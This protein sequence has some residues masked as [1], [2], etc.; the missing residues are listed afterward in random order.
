M[1]RP[2]ESILPYMLNCINTNSTS[3]SNSLCAFESSPIE[4]LCRLVLV[5]GFCCWVVNGSHPPYSA[6]VK[7]IQESDQLD[8]D[9]ANRPFFLFYTRLPFRPTPLSY[10]SYHDYFHN[11]HHPPPQTLYDIGYYIQL[12]GDLFLQHAEHVPS[13]GS[14][15]GEKAREVSGKEPCKHHPLQCWGDRRPLP[16][17]QACFWNNLGLRDLW[18]LDPR[19]DRGAQILLKVV[20]LVVTLCVLEGTLTLPLP[21]VII[22]H[23]LAT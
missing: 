17:V 6:T 5:F 21:L 3:K 12:H 18:L 16:Y 15:E 4:F 1:Q 2:W 20:F 14:F 22:R 19:L 13:L 10:C 8:T 9:W 7:H 11:Y 23:F